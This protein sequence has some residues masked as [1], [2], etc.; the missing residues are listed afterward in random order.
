MKVNIQGEE[1]ELRKFTLKDREILENKSIVINQ[2]QEPRILSGTVK[3][4]SI[5]LGC[6]KAPFFKSDIVDV[7]GVTPRLLNERLK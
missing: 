4:Y 6:K 7:L 2:D 5:L 1:F 3:I